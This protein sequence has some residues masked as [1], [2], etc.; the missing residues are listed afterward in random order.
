MIIL[1]F[2]LLATLFLA[3]ANGANDNFKGVATLWG[4]GTTS[5]KKSLYWA[6]VTTFLGSLAALFIATKLITTFSG[7]GLVPD[8][9]VNDP[10]FLISVG[11][12]AALTVF[13]ATIIG[14]PISTTHSL[15]G[16][17]IGAG[18][19]AA[20]TQ[21]NFHTLENKFFLPLLL[22]PAIAAFFTLI[23]YPGFK[24]ARVKLGIEH[25]MCLCIG[26]RMEPVA[27]Q[28]DG[29]AVLKS[30][31]LTLTIDQL[32][33]CQPYYRGKILGFDSQALL[34]KFHYVSAGAV[35]FARGLND[36]PK[37]VALLLVMGA[38]SLKW[39]IFM[40]AL[41]MAIGGLLNAKKIA[42][43]M[44]ERITKMNHGQ[45]FS[46]NLVTALLVIFASRWGLPVSTTH[47]SCGSL[48]G[49]GLVNK[50]ANLSVIRQIILAWVLTLPLAAILSGVC[51]LV[52]SH[53]K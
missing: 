50:K 39:G 14:I 31:G 23:I 30:T 7:K 42:I 3:Y 45:G 25:Q 19:M 1:V 5:Y 28:Q 46:A 26:E 9:I 52:I 53:I 24:L 8:A 10:H 20:G 27:I 51:F 16:A 22:S 21:I 48:F 34:D 18:L 2:V 29:T 38:F 43:T 49:I 36:T 35:S 37:I 47:V 41:A 40:V 17:L 6:T 4:S 11:L 12:G 33:N 32:Q 13:I 15:T 44:S